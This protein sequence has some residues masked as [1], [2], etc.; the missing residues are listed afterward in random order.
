MKTIL[1]KTMKKV[2]LTLAI[3]MMSV[4]AFGQTVYGVI[5]NSPNHTTLTAAIDA[6]GLD[7][8][9]DDP[10]GEF[11]V[12]APDNNAF[13]DLL[14]ELGITAP[15]LL[16]DAGLADILTYHVLGSEVMAA[17]ITNGDIV[18]PINSNNTLKLTVNA[19][20]EVF[21]N[22]AQVNAADLAASNGVV[23]S[24][25]QALLVNETV[26][27]LAIDNGFNILVAAVVEARLLPALTDPFAE[28]TVFAPTDA[29][30]TTYITNSGITAP[31]LLASAGLA[32]IL[33]YHVLGMEVNSADLTDGMVATL[34]GANILVDL[35]NGVMINDAMVTTADV[36]SDNGVVHVIDKVLVPG[37]ASIETNK[38]E[39]ITVFPN[40]TTSVIQ[41]ENMEN[42]DYRITNSAGKIVKEGKLTS[43][44]I[45]VN[46]LENGMYFLYLIEGENV[47][48]SQFIKK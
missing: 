23:H 29:A 16:A 36:A 35:S 7:A 11:T 47:F 14:A 9:L 24:I 3:A 42:A 8:T 46:A 31:D 28:Y 27:D 10:M 13:A 21:V 34:N 22:Q 45:Q 40:P 15:D 44:N 41:V 30:F 1:S 2:S 26:A 39:E 5:S 19:S 25:D 12:F 33:L 43:N 6:A 37:T 18:T 48:T 17:G 32:D 4:S 20:S 38:F